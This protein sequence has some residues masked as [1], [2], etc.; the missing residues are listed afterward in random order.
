MAELS[1][2][3]ASCLIR[4]V[5]S[6]AA[7]QHWVAH[8]KN[9]EFV[10]CLAVA[11]S[12]YGCST[13]ERAALETQWVASLAPHTL[14]ALMQEQMREFLSAEDVMTLSWCALMA[15]K[16]GAQNSPRSISEMRQ[17]F[18]RKVT[19]GD[20]LRTCGTMS[21]YAKRTASERKAFTV[22]EA[23]A[24]VRRVAQ[25]YL[26]KMGFGSAAATYTE[27]V[28]LEAARIVHVRL[29]FGTRGFALKVKD[30]H[31]EL[32]KQH[33]RECRTKREQLLE[34]FRADRAT[35]SGPA[36][37]REFAEFEAANAYPRAPEPCAVELAFGSWD[38]S[39]PET[40]DQLLVGAATRRA[41]ACGFDPKTCAPSY[42]NPR[43]ATPLKV[44][45][46]F[47]RNVEVAFGE[48]AFDWSTALSQP[49]DAFK[50]TMFAHCLEGG[51][52][53][54]PEQPWEALALCAYSGMERKWRL[55]LLRSTGGVGS[56]TDPEAAYHYFREV[57]RFYWGREDGDSKLARELKAECGGQAFSEMLAWRREKSGSLALEFLRAAALE[58]FARDAEFL[59][60]V[61]Q[62]TEE[63]ELW[64]AI[65]SRL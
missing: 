19:C 1:R 12:Q 38:S 39:F 62:F 14:P 37:D 42:L 29:A 9:P 31:D 34:M 28:D 61:A 21:E 7:M 30:A 40:R 11:Y 50:R 16:K 20:L 56:L 43:A 33:A 4:S 64:R 57:W 15:A 6:Y 3:T 65:E 35:K 45:E 32:V 8:D 55:A 44:R 5:W 58:R 27:L 18:A 2:A 23:E 36:F 49:L 63:T 53:G 25:L 17:R 51:S 10:A 59:K 54:D 24:E 48:H 13:V 41:V 46:R 26:P 52:E 47:K 60:T 22:K